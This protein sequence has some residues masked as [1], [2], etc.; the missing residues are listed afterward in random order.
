VPFTGVRADWLP[1]H[2][3]PGARSTGRLSSRP[4]NVYVVPYASVHAVG[5]AYLILPGTDR[6]G[7]RRGRTRDGIVSR[8]HVTAICRGVG[9]VTGI[10]CPGSTWSLGRGTVHVHVVPLTGVRAGGL[11]GHVVPCPD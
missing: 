2:V 10:V 11:P 6:T 8:G 3:V 4:V 5:L 1:G 9:N 7:N